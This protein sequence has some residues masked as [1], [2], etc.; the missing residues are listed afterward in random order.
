MIYNNQVYLFFKYNSDID[1]STVFL[2]F[3]TLSIFFIILSKKKI[4]DTHIQFILI[5]IFSI[6]F[7]KFIDNPTYNTDRYNQLT[8]I[9]LFKYGFYSTGIENILNLKT[10]VNSSLLLSFLPLPAPQN[11]LDLALYNKIIYLFLISF[12]IKKKYS[13]EFTWFVIFAPTFFYYSSMGGKEMLI[14]FISFF[15]TRSL[16]QKKYIKNFMLSCI[17]VLVKFEFGFLLLFFSFFYFTILSNFFNTYKKIILIIVLYL[18]A[19]VLFYKYN[20]YINH[21][22][23]GFYIYSDW[24]NIQSLYIFVFLIFKNYIF[25]PIKFFDY[26]NFKLIYLPFS[27]SLIFNYIFFYYVFFKLKIFKKNFKYKLEILLFVLFNIV[28]C[29]IYALMIENFGTFQR[30]VTTPMI[31]S[32]FMILHFKQK[33]KNE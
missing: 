32:I 17:L 1:Y 30:L 14:F 16:I 21:K 13:K 23:Q 7:F 33:A 28:F 12:L 10:S 19:E 31:I 4:E 11:L 8:Y 18:L 2:F 25:I 26:H 15:W 22:F 5:S 27:L 24:K 20:N 29:G 6:F 9:S 3:I